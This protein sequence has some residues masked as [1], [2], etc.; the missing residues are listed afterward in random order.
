M[1]VRV[2]MLIVIGA[3]LLVPFIEN[4]SSSRYQQV[5]RE[6]AEQM[7]KDSKERTERQREERK[8]RAEER[9]ERATEKRQEMLT[10]RKIVELEERIQ[11]MEYALQPFIELPDQLINSEDKDLY[12]STFD[13]LRNDACV[14]LV[15]NNAIRTANVAGV[16]LK[17]RKTTSQLEDEV[18]RIILERFLERNRWRKREIKK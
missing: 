17:S 9:K 4:V 18:Y 14:A 15:V 12:K 13:K 10:N 8:A 11:Q 5:S 1:N 16:K 2:S 6:R 3:I 7:R